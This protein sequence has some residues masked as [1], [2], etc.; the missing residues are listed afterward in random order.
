[1]DRTPLSTLNA[2][3]SW[4]SIDVPEYQPWIGRRPV[5]VHFT[6]LGGSS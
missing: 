5:R 1:M 6:F 2:S 3:V 4:E